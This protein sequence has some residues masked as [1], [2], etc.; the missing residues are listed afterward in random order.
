[1]WLQGHLGGSSG[2]GFSDTWVVVVGVAFLQG[3]V[4]NTCMYGIR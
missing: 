2:C 1:M 4:W 3:A